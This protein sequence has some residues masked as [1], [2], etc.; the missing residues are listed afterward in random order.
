MIYYYDLHCFFCSLKSCKLQWIHNNRN[1]NHKSTWLMKE[2]NLITR[3]PKLS[4]NDAKTCKNWNRSLGRKPIAIPYRGLVLKTRPVC[5][6][7]RTLSTVVLPIH[8]RIL[9]LLWQREAF[10]VL[11]SPVSFLSIVNNIFLIFILPCVDCPIKLQLPLVPVRK[12]QQLDF[13]NSMNSC[14]FFKGL[15]I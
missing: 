14:H 3:N 7:H 11:F 12:V 10:E 6:T 4:E 2:N 8:I 9:L 1:H 13:C 15:W 5:P